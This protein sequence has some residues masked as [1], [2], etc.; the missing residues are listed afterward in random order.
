MF[1]LPGT[2]SL[3]DSAHRPSPTF[4]KRVPTALSSSS[5]ATFGSQQNGFGAQLPPNPFAQPATLAGDSRHATPSSPNAASPFGQC[6]SQYQ[7]PTAQASA[8]SQNTAVNPPATGF[9]SWVSPTASPF[10]E[11]GLRRQTSVAPT[12]APTTTLNNSVPPTGFSSWDTQS[13]ASTTAP[14]SPFL[15]QVWPSKGLVL[16]HGLPMGGGCS[17]QSQ[18][19]YPEPEP[20]MVNTHATPEDS[21]IPDSNTQRASGVAQSTQPQESLSSAF[22]GQTEQGAQNTCMYGAPPSKSSHYHV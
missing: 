7:S 9:S 20:A 12:L 11:P 16:N 22:N 6:S 14:Q 18:C 3:Q 21:S 2:P 15:D 5:Q 10:Q 13:R 1:R 19:S 17:Y 4:D 8:T